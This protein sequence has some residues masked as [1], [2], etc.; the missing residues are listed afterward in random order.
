VGLFQKCFND[1][2]YLY[3][4]PFE[5]DRKKRQV[6]QVNSPREVFLRRFHIPILSGLS[7]ILGNTYVLQYNHRFPKELD[8]SFL[9]QVLL[10]T[11]I[12]AFLGQIYA[13][14]FCFI[15]YPHQVVLGLNRLLSYNDRISK[16]KLSC[17]ETVV[18]LN[19]N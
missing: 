3:K 12:A 9:A 8:I 15:A 5:W 4:Y 11:G 6:V 7:G 10:Y 14:W 13:H 17:C 18:E 2:Y 19:S 16:L 1:R